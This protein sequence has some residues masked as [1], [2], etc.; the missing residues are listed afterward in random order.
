MLESNGVFQLITKSTRVTKNSSSLIVHIFISALSNPI[1]LK[2]I[3][4]D[5][6]DHFITYCV[7]SL[8]SN[9]ESVKHKKYFCRDIKSLDVE[10]YLLDRDKENEPI[11]KLS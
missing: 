9:P 10:S 6:S 2:K 4:N 7:I 3:L 1:F 8:K 11:Q 5:T